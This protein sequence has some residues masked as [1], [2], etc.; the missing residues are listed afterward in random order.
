VRARRARGKNMLMGLIL[1]L[2]RWVFGCSVAVVSL[3]MV[4]GW[5]TFNAGY[6]YVL[7]TF[8]P[9]STNPSSCRLYPIF[10]EKW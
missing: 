10:L 9:P 4:D 5:D 7:Y 3:L 2:G 1:W 6:K 8:P